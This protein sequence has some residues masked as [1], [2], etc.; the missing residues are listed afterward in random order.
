MDLHFQGTTT[1]FD[2]LEGRRAAAAAAAKQG[3][4]ILYILIGGTELADLR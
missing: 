4:S 3:N 2:R 1:A